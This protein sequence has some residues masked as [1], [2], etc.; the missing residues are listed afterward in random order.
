L[1]HIVVMLFSPAST[2]QTTKKKDLIPT[3][4]PM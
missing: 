2:I 1:L 3:A 4:N